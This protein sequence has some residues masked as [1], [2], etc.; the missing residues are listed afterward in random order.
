MEVAGAGVVVVVDFATVVVV[1]ESGAVVVDTS[2]T[3]VDDS[4][5]FGA[6]VVVVRLV[7]VLLAFRTLS[8]A[9]A[10]TKSQGASPSVATSMKSFQILAG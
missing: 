6:A 4:G 7:G 2:G 5:A 9:S 10:S 1:E 3:V 8:P